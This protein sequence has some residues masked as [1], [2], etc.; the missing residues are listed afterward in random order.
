MSH[1]K[2]LLSSKHLCKDVLVVLDWLERLEF[3]S[4][5]EF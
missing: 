4:K 3:D 5:L 1:I 2:Y